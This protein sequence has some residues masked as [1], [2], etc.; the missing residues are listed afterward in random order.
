VIEST[1]TPENYCRQCL[2]WDTNSEMGHVISWGAITIDQKWSNCKIN[3]AFVPWT[4]QSFIVKILF[5]WFGLIITIWTRFVIEKTP[6]LSLY[7]KKIESGD[8]SGKRW[9]KHKN[10]NFLPYISEVL[11]T[12]KTSSRWRNKRGLTFAT[13]PW[14]I[15][16]NGLFPFHCA[17]PNSTLSTVNLKMCWFKKETFQNYLTPNVVAFSL[18][19]IPQKT[20]NDLLK[21]KKCTYLS[22][23]H[24]D[25]QL[26]MIIMLTWWNNNERKFIL[27]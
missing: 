15:Q 7:Y 16:R 24:I 10:K 3:T 19:E 22:V 6:K 23:P 4:Q 18:S 14:S 25:P 12:I 1:V 11:F 9:S 8:F 21:R 13:L 17:C 26:C 2:K 27:L 20:L 5:W